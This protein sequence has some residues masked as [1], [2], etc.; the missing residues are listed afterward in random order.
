MHSQ[1]DRSRHEFIEGRHERCWWC[2]RPFAVVDSVMHRFKGKD[3]HYYCSVA[4]ASALYLSPQ[5]VGQ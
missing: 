5:Q 1:L 3:E 2:H 4:H